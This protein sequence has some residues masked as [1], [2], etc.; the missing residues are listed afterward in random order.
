MIDQAHGVGACSAHRAAHVF[1]AIKEFANFFRIRYAYEVQSTAG[2]RVTMNHLY[3]LTAM[4]PQLML[5][6]VLTA[7]GGDQARKGLP[8]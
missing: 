4:I 7:T 1:Y 5:D 3:N 6:A 2:R 8:G